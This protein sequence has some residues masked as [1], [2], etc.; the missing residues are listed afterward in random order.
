MNTNTSKSDDGR[1][2]IRTVSEALDKQRFAMLTL[3]Q[4][5]KQLASRPLTLA[6]QDDDVLSFLVDRTAHWVGFAEQ[7]APANIAFSDPSSGTFIS[8]SGHARVVN[9]RTR[10]DA[11]WSPADSAFFADSSD[12]N[13]AIVEVR[14]EEGEYWDGPGN[15]AVAGIKLAARA[16]GLN[17]SMGE[18]GM[19]RPA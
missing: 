17:V 10:I 18:K 4:D 13:I 8:L 15:S 2:H 1:G 16:A 6:E 5:N 11:L 19:V 12:P 7:G 3:A 9:D 14:V